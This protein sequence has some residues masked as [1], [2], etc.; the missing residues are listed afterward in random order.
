MALAAKGKTKEASSARAQFEKS[1]NAIPAEMLFLVNNKAAD[2]LALAAATLDAQIAW[3]LGEKEESV[4]LWRR[5]VEVERTIQYDEPPAWFYPV[6]Q[7]LAAAL[8]QSGKAK[9]AEAV[10]REAI[11]RQPRDGRLLFGLWQS[12]VAQKRDSEAAMV[13]SQ[14][15][16]AWKGATSKLAIEDL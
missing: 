8:L 6:R 1:R 5:A 12:L 16:T 15:E 4:R 14:F 10:F 2:I 11:A 13:Q 9:E 3:A 7:S